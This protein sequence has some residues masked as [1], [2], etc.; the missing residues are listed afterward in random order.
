MVVVQVD[1]QHAVGAQS[2][3]AIVIKPLRAQGHR[4]ALVV[5]AID[6]QHIKGGR[7]GLQ[8][9]RTVGGNH[10]KSRAVV[11]H[12]K[13]V[14]QVNHIGVDLQHRHLARR[15]LPVAEFGE[16]ATTQPDHAD[17]PWRRIEQ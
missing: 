10:L 3:E 11:G 6:Q 1:R 5:K 13:L 15:Q 14:A 2:R 4:L 8:I 17:V 16:R 7:F 12:L 9:K